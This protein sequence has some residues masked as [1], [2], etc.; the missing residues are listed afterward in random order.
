MPARSLFDFQFS[1]FFSRLLRNRFT[2][3]LSTRRI[4]ACRNIQSPF[5][6]FLIRNLG[7]ARIRENKP[8]TNHKGLISPVISYLSCMW[9][10]NPS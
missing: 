7:K 8:I 10:G 9:S 4:N 2:Y 1:K 6:R 5:I 3:A